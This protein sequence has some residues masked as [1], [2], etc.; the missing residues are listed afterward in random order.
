MKNIS[1]VPNFFIFFENASNWIY[2][3]GK[4]AKEMSFYNW[5]VLRS[6]LQQKNGTSIIWLFQKCCCVQTNF[7]FKDEVW[8]FIVTSGNQNTLYV[9]NQIIQTEKKLEMKSVVVFGCKKEARKM[10]KCANNHTIPFHAWRLKEL[11]ITVLLFIGNLIVTRHNDLILQLQIIYK[12][13]FKILSFLTWTLI[14]ARMLCIFLII[15]YI[16]PKK[17]GSTFE[18][19]HTISLLNIWKLYTSMKINR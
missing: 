6:P 19:H 1:F 8:R 18:N 17:C 10:F 9:S 4:V 11:I 2:S 15:S 16:F 7:I 12:L 5:K 3:A 14:S 13:Q